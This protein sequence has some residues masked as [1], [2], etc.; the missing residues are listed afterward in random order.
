MDLDDEEGD[1][2]SQQHFHQDR[3]QDIPAPQELPFLSDVADRVTPSQIASIP[4]P[5]I[6]AFAVMSV[7][8]APHMLNPLYLLGPG[9]L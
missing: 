4:H 7:P 1:S 8:N 9:W 2:A 3:H 5:T 6:P